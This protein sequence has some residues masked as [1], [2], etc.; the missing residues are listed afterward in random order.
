M[1]QKV[2]A[3][4]Q[5]SEAGAVA[6]IQEAWTALQENE[7]AHKANR[8]A[9]CGLMM[10]Y[11]KKLL[12]GREAC[13]SAANGKV[14]DTTFGKWLTDNGVDHVEKDQRAAYIKLAEHETE[15]MALLK[16]TASKSV[17]LIWD[18]L[19][20][21]LHP[22]K[23]KAKRMAAKEAKKSKPKA[24][25]ANAQADEVQKAALGEDE[26]VACFK[27]DVLPSVSD[28]V[29]QWLTDKAAEIAAYNKKSI[30]VTPLW[31]RK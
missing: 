11:A 18:E 26:F 20:A 23:P 14:N 21:K 24:K 1:Q 22:D 30:R 9:W 16:A 31:S 8:E 27:V 3:A 25:S 13:R 7:A 4:P 6:A 15:G 2:D 29:R 12:A 19:D 17:R 28:E 10:A 5:P